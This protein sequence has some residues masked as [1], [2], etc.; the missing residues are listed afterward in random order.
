MTQLQI[1]RVCGPSKGETNTTTT[2]MGSVIM[3]FRE[4][5]LIFGT[6]GRI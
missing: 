5:R 1:V 6:I 4:L 3:E 2:K